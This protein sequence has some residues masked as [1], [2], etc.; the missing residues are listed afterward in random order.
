MQILPAA[1]RYL[2]QVAIVSS[3]TTIAARIA[4]EILSQTVMIGY[5]NTTWKPCWSQRFTNITWINS[6]VNDV[7]TRIPTDPNYQSMF[8]DP[9]IWNMMMQTLKSTLERKANILPE[10]VSSYEQFS[11]ELES[12]RSFD[13]LSQ[14]A[15]ILH[16]YN[17]SM[18]ESF[19]ALLERLESY[20]HDGDVQ[21]RVASFQ[22]L[23]S[24][25]YQSFEV[26]EDPNLDYI[27][28]FLSFMTAIT[29]ISFIGWLLLVA[30]D[31]KDSSKRKT[32]VS[33][34]QFMVNKVR[35]GFSKSNRIEKREEEKKWSNQE[36]QVLAQEAKERV[37]QQRLIVAE[38]D[39]LSKEEEQRK[40]KENY[41]AQV[42]AEQDS[43]RQKV[44][45]GENL[46]FGKKK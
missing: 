9:D 8:S 36:M 17:K 11:K 10:H 12:I 16:A 15:L 24:A 33:F 19:Y 22:E 7:V 4:N 2:G 29:A 14:Y 25:K 45:S 39:K 23:L 40:W 38:K 6:I 1:E 43:I 34:T 30:K 3:L 21:S 35:P 26:C 27:N 44:A 32:N 46:D 31:W 13:A 5:V 41:E 20:F 28:H 37:L 42:K 18:E